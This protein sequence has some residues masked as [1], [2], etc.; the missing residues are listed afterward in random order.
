VGRTTEEWHRVKSLSIS[1][2]FVFTLTLPYPS[3]HIPMG[4]NPHW[5]PAHPSTRRE[6]VF[7]CSK[8]GCAPLKLPAR[9]YLSLRK[10]GNKGDLIFV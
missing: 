4:I 3:P 1:L 8:R 5:M 7:I 6:R 2:Y 9:F 10:R